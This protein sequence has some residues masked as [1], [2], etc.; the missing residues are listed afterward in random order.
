MVPE[1]KEEKAIIA[2]LAE[3]GWDVV[4]FTASKR[5]AKLPHNSAEMKAGVARPIISYVR[6]NGPVT[7]AGKYR[8][9]FSTGAYYEGLDKQALAAIDSGK[10]S[11][12]FDYE[13]WKFVTRQVPARQECLSCH[14]ERDGL[15]VKVGDNIGIFL[16][17]FKKVADSEKLPPLPAR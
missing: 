4:A 13:S 16:L 14:I 5:Y 12:E 8:R 11:T 10:D 6:T 1:N 3:G 17:G 15:K 9:D 2:A 7:I